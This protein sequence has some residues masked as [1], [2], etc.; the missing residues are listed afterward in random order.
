M[1][2]STGMAMVVCT[3]GMRRIER[4]R[5][6]AGRRRVGLLA[7]IWAMMKGLHQ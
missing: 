3:G 4:G 5:Q 2:L 7:E 6:R 1:R